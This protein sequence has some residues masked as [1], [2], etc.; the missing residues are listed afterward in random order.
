MR[1]FLP[2]FKM[3][4]EGPLN[5]PLNALGMKQAF[6]RNADFSAMS[7]AKPL[8]ISLVQ[9]KAFVE[10]NEAGAEAA[11]AT[12]VVMSLESIPAEPS[13]VV[14]ADRPFLFTIR[15]RATGT[16]LFMGRVADPRK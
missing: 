6:A 1:L 3:T 4:W 15:D 5:E 16:V 14:R 11:A 12:G 13:A 2:R 7:D 8:Y 9:H 10:V